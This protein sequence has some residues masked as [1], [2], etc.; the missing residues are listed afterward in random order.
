M[1]QFWPNATWKEILRTTN[2]TTAGIGSTATGQHTPQPSETKNFKRTHT[3]KL[4]SHIGSDFHIWNSFAV[5][6]QFYW[7]IS[8]IVG[9]VVHGFTVFPSIWCSIQPV[10]ALRFRFAGDEAGD[11]RILCVKFVYDREF[12]SWFCTRFCIQLVYQ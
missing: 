5:Y 7:L 2:K 10:V 12:C 4:L 3:K 9:V 6:L 1:H 8:T 11:D